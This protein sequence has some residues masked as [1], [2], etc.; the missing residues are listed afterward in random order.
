MAPTMDNGNRN[1]GNRDN[2]DADAV[3]RPGKHDPRSGQDPQGPITPHLSECDLSG[4]DLSIPNE[5]LKEAISMVAV[6]EKLRN[7]EQHL[8]GQPEQVYEFARRLADRLNEHLVPVGFNLAA[9]L[10][11]YDLQDHG[12]VRLRMP[13]IADVVLPEGFAKA[14]GGIRAAAAA[15]PALVDAFK[16][17]MAA[18]VSANDS[19]L[20]SVTGPFPDTGTTT[21][22]RTDPSPAQ[23][24]RK[25]KHEPRQPS[26]ED[27]DIAE[28]FIA[29]NVTNNVN[30][31]EEAKTHLTEKARSVLGVWNNPAVKSVIQEGNRITITTGN[32]STM[33]E[34]LS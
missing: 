10:L 9:E 30:L 17:P 8:P 24:R 4:M 28:S 29:K 20:L 5:A 33:Y 32:G 18:G 11:L 25:Q 19:G 31:S 27:L 21:G 3:A 23:N 34:Y 1:D 15:V 7:L 6:K 12:A 16:D 2:G 22:L 14:V 26:T 13:Q